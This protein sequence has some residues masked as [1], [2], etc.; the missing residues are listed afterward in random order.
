[1]S[2]DLLLHAVENGAADFDELI[3]ESER[4]WQYWSDDYRL[5]RFDADADP[6]R[7]ASAVGWRR[8]PD[9]TWNIWSAAAYEIAYPG[10]YYERVAT[11]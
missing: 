7:D 3:G 6:I 9:G 8:W 1:M 2:V 11:P 10:G 4:Q 5:V